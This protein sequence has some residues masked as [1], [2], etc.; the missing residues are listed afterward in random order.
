VKA[1]LELGVQLD[2]Y[3]NA[4]VNSPAAICHAAHVQLNAEDEESLTMTAEGIDA[5]PGLDL[6]TPGQRTKDGQDQCV[7]SSCTSLLQMSSSASIHAT[8]EHRDPL[9]PCDI[10]DTCLSPGNPLHLLASCQ[11]TPRVLKQIC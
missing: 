2:D 6:P 8:T 11:G 10:N 7:S 3:V 1:I 9:P 4:L 5:E